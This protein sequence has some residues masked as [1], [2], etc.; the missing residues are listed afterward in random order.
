MELLR[1]WVVARL[2][3]RI[4]E[5]FRHLYLRQ[6][7]HLQP[8]QQQHATMPLVLYCSHNGWSDVA[9][10]IVLSYG[11]LHL[12]SLFLVTP[13]QLEHF[14]ILR[15]CR[16]VALQWNS[17]EEF[18]LQLPALLQRIRPGSVLWVFATGST[19]PPEQ[20]KPCWGAHSLYSG[21]SIRSRWRPL[22]G[23][24]GCCRRSPPATY[25]SAHPSG[26]NHRTA[27]LDRSSSTAA[28]VSRSSTSGSNWSSTPLRPRGHTSAIG[29]RLRLG[30][31]Q[32]LHNERILQRFCMADIPRAEHGEGEQL[33]ELRHGVPGK[34]A[35]VA[36]CSR[37]CPDPSDGFGCAEALLKRSIHSGNRKA[38]PEGAA[39][40][41]AP[42]LFQEADQLPGADAV[43]ARKP[44]AIPEAAFA[45]G[46]RPLPQLLLEVPP[47]PLRLRRTGNGCPRSDELEEV[48]GNEVIAALV[49][50]QEQL[51]QRTVQHRE[52][53]NPGRSPSRCKA[54]MHLNTART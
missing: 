31:A 24:T 13:H 47:C 14:S 25:G 43:V 48:F 26:S 41:F 53:N 17:T 8:W 2:R 21:S 49:D 45:T 5:L 38:A 22:H 15:Y 20:P 46:D 36:Q 4:R 54:P 23:T 10:A 19:S 16:A 7:E 50:Q 33:A 35:G 12:P 37:L 11:P 18:E 28:A 42:Y 44:R 6:V 1:R 51:L 39:V 29:Y 27:P 40:G 52:L 32:E 9:L 30:K 3:R 34:S